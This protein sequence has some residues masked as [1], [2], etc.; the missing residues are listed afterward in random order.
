MPENIR[1]LKRNPQVDAEFVKILERTLEEVRL[2]EV[3]GMTLVVSLTKD[4]YTIR[5]AWH[6]RLEH[7]G[8]LAQA[9]HNTLTS[10]EDA[11]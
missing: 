7:A 9:L 11:E 1:A 8:A 3:T 6:R 2:G 10:E 4:R 5:R